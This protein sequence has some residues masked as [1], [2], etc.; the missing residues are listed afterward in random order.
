[1]LCEIAQ[2]I[3]CVFLECPEYAGSPLNMEGREP[4]NSHEVQ[5]ASRVRLHLDSHQTSDLTSQVFEGVF[6]A[7]FYAGL[8]EGVDLHKFAELSDA[9]LPEHKMRT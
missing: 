6:F 4:R 7:G 9:D 1:M 8:I 2:H 3:R 5:E